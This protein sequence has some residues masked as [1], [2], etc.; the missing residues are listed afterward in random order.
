[1]KSIL[2]RNLRKIEIKKININ[3]NFEMTK[4]DILDPANKLKF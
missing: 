3:F 4:N 2:E 1:M